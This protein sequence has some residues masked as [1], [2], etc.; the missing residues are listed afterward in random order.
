MIGPKTP[1]IAI[2]KNDKGAYVVT[3]YG[4]VAHWPRI[5]DP[6]PVVNK[7]KLTGAVTPVMNKDGSQKQKWSVALYLPKSAP[8]ANDLHAACVEVRKNELKG[9]GKIAA[10]KDGDR[11]LARLVA[12]MGKDP[13]KLQHM[14]G[15][16]IISASTTIAPIIHNEIYAGAIC[17]AVIQ[18][19]SY[20]LETKGV[21]AYL[22]EIGRVA[23]GE[24]LATGGQRASVLA[25]AMAFEAD[26]A[27]T[28]SQPST[29][30][31]AA[32]GTDGMPW[33]D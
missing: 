20:D 7:D 29:G 1:S 2:N 22:Q 15:Q 19:A 27:P 23:P 17:V 14:V 3:V 12:E 32:A 21:K 5:Q 9:V 8:G 18:L 16:A 28:A 31:P 13:E 6:E 10:M 25:G 24:R 33:E 30:A 4:A 11:E 26:S